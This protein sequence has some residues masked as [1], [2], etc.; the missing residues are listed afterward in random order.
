ML[1]SIHECLQKF[2]QDLAEGDV[3]VKFKAMPKVKPPRRNN[4]VQNESNRSDYMQIYMRDYREEGK[5]YQKK[6]DNMK[7]FKKKHKRKKKE[8]H[9]KDIRVYNKALP[10]D[11]I[12]IETKGNVGL[13]KEPAET[14]H[15]ANTPYVGIRLNYPTATFNITSNDSNSNNVLIIS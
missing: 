11:Q 5:D 9:I 10:P 14:L 3:V 2:A 13:Y 7:E 1:C 6:P 8:G 4:P 15:I 12:Y